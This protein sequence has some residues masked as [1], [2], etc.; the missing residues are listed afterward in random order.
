MLV[1]KLDKELG[2][3]ENGFNYK[4][5]GDGTVTIT[6]Y[7]D[8][9]KFVYIPEILGGKPVTSI[10]N[11]AFAGK[12]LESVTIPDGVTTIGDKAFFN[13]KLT[14][15]TIPNSVTHIN[16]GAFSINRLKDVVISANLTAI[17]CNTFSSNKLENVIIPKS[18]NEITGP[19][20]YN[21]PLKTVEFEGTL[22]LPDAFFTFEPLDA[23]FQGWFTDK[24]FSNPWN[25]SVP[26]SVTI[27]AK[28]V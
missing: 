12:Q 20:F 5:N 3:D 22:A 6:G 28:W 4:D 26:Q 25:H 21:N 11:N 14:N 1:N 9:G 24:D 2:I 23:K 19:V 8:T 16:L 10:G 17:T 13:N 18:V 7:T 15:I 27:Y